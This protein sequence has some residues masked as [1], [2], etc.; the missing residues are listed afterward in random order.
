MTIEQMGITVAAFM[1]AQGGPDPED[2]LK[3]SY[4][5]AKPNAG[6]HDHGGGCT[7]IMGA[8]AVLL[9]GAINGGYT[10]SGEPKAARTK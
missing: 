7:R 9:A 3:T 2:P 5:G 10:S 4:L 6:R 1:R 8:L